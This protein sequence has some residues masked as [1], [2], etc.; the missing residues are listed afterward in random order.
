MDGPTEALQTLHL[1]S[2]GMFLYWLYALKAQE[3]VPHH[4]TGE[5]VKQHPVYL[6]TLEIKV[7]KV[8]PSSLWL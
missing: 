8:D 1:M 5:R 7:S 4:M 3:T 2:D 6:Q